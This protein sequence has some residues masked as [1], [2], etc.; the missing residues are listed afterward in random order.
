MNPIRSL[1][2][3]LLLFFTGC[4]RQQPQTPAEPLPTP[5]RM[6]APSPTPPPADTESSIQREQTSGTLSKWIDELKGTADPGTDRIQYQ[7]QAVADTSADS[8]S[9]HRETS[10]IA[11]RERIQVRHPAFRNADR[12]TVEKKPE[13]IHHVN[14]SV[15]NHAAIAKGDV[16]LVQAYARSPESPGLLH[17][18]A[19]LPHE[20]F[21]GVANLNTEIPPDWQNV[22]LTFKAAQD[23]RPGDLQFVCFFGE[24]KQIV[25]IGGFS[26]LNL[27]STPSNEVIALH[28]MPPG[29]RSDFEEPFVSY[30]SPAGA[31]SSIS[32]SLPSAWR[33]DSS[34][35]PVTGVYGKAGNGAFAGTGALSMDI[36][37]VTKGR[38]QL[39][40]PH[41]HVSNK[42]FMFVRMAIRSGSNSS[43]EV[44]LR[45]SG[46]PYTSYWQSTFSARPE[47]TVVEA[48]IP[49]AR[50][51]EPDGTFMLMM[52][53]PGI[54]EL[55]G[56]E[57]MYLSPELALGDASYQGNLLHTSSFPLGIT[58]PWAAKDD[59]IVYQTTSSKAPTGQPGLILHDT[60]DGGRRVA[61]LIT[62]FQGKQG[63][64]HT[65]SLW[66]K[67][68]EP[69]KR[70]HIRMGPP[71]EDLWKPPFQKDVLLTDKWERY[72]FTL[73]LPFSASGFYMAQLMAH[74][75]GDLHV[76]GLM[77][78]VGETMS[79]FERTAETELHLKA[80]QNFYALYTENEPFTYDMAVYGDVPGTGLVIRSELIDIYDHR[81]E[82]PEIALD[83]LPYIETHTLPL[84]DTRAFGSYVLKSAVFDAEG[85]QVSRFA[86]VI[87][88]RIRSPRHPDAYVYESPFGVHFKN[89]PINAA[90]AKRLGA[91]WVRGN[92]IVS[93][94]AVEPQPG[95]WNWSSVESFVRNL[96]ANKL[97]GLAYL[98]GVPRWASTADSTWTRSWYRT[99]AAVSPDKY[100][101]W[102]EY[103]TRLFRRYGNRI[104]AWENWNE[105]YWPGF[106][107]MDEVNGQPVRGTPDMFME[108][109][110][111]VKRAAAKVD[112][113]LELIWNT[114]FHAQSGAK[115]F[116]QELLRQGILE[117]TDH[118]SIHGY[119]TS[120]MGYP[121]DY[122]G[123]YLQEIA[124]AFGTYRV[125]A[126]IWNT[127]GG[128]GPSKIINLYTDSA[129]RGKRKERHARADFLVRYYIS[130]LSKGIEK[131]FYYAFFQ[132]NTWRKSYTCHNADG[133]MSN[134]HVAYSNLAWHLEGKPFVKT[135]PLQQDIYAHLFHGEQES[136][137]VI[138]GKSTGTL[139]A[140]SKNVVLRDLYGNEP[141]GD[142]VLG[143]QTVY[144][145]GSPAD[146]TTFLTPYLRETL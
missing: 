52:S 6:P 84:E 109:A 90:A 100:D 111:R 94:A 68:D 145:I 49:P 74:D 34:W 113:D 48:L 7:N 55:D 71:E 66:A 121:D 103:A 143:P 132:E 78:E 31:E 136:V 39:K 87:L 32:G 28:T 105:P 14:L 101:E 56:F 137:A 139:T 25:E 134:V 135:V 96:E 42:Y 64:T 141:R 146:L 9:F 116:E 142:M 23:Y 92:Y 93:W 4:V 65:F 2:L 112:P 80:H 1:F 21:K 15:W 12:I 63:E 82:L 76:D 17:I 133:T 54:L 79:P 129:P 97:H 81:T 124:H 20:Q 61:G 51:D 75:R 138:I 73:K 59:G 83:A 53:K 106:F 50:E 77:V 22:H 104:T 120:M 46:P 5:T 60:P 47:W 119:P 130:N 144:A 85:H 10:T 127:E 67:T 86:E 123:K 107:P 91:N 45:K 72:S 40:L 58:A 43:F 13:V 35:A 131:F 16:I 117:V 8:L 89:T 27:G 29:Y 3:I 18:Y 33:E 102:E 95:N 140:T 26:I 69:G 37:Q 11:S 110:R 99:T 19:Q 44:S 115:Q 114:G 128:S 125:P 30:T 36:R 88:H 70:L 24:R 126:Q 98:G 108:Q 41:V 62:P 122:F 38:A 57:L 118:L